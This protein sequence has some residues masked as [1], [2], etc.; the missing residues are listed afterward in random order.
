M[1]R[2]L[3]IGGNSKV[4]SLLKNTPYRDMG[5]EF[6]FQSR[7]LESQNDIYWDP[8]ASKLILQSK[9]PFKHEYDA[10]LNLAGPTDEIYCDLNIEIAERCCQLAQ[11]YQI[12]KVIL[13]S[14]SAVYGNKNILHSEISSC[15]PISNYGKSKIQMEQRCLELSLNSEIICLRL[16]NI[17]G[18]D[19]LSKKIENKQRVLLDVGANYVSAK[20]SY[21]SPYTFVNVLKGL[22]NLNNF[23]TPILNVSS[24]EP[25]Y[26]HDLLEILKMPYDR[27]VN[28]KKVYDVSLDTTLLSQI[29][30]FRKKD[31][32]LLS[33]VEEMSWK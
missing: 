12:P 13:I 5:L 7:K 6:Y 18:A 19:A 33:L 22:L 3:V 25:F 32:N 21:L 1:K 30:K 15:R 26:M 16:G 24:P 8:L 20:R 9:K 14:S 31:E 29:V 2:V 28:V 17:L 27:R 4:A 10:I 23:D 11:V